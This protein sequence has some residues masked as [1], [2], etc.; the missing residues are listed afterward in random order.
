MTKPKTKTEYLKKWRTNRPVPM[1]EAKLN[2]LIRD[3][4]KAMRTINN[5]G[6]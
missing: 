4:A 3:Q 2:T 5:K 1:D 6:K